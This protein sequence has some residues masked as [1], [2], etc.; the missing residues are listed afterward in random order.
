MFDLRSAHNRNRG[1]S[2]E[3]AVVIG[4]EGIR[5]CITVVPFNLGS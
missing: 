3:F 4:L 2:S 1:A 5:M